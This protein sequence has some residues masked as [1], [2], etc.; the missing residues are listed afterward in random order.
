MRLL[1]RAGTMVFFRHDQMDYRCFGATFRQAKCFGFGVH[2]GSWKP[3]TDLTKIFVLVGF[4]H[5]ED[6]VPCL[7]CIRHVGQVGRGSWVRR[8]RFHAREAQAFYKTA[9]K[10]VVSVR[11]LPCRL[12][13]LFEI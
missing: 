10:D 13:R 1:L 12:S 11:V 7:A 6:V 4:L 8:G 9:K 3:K 2:D 5:A